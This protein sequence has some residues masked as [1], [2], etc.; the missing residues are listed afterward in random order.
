M[1]LAEIVDQTKFLRQVQEFIMPSSSCTIPIVENNQG[2][3]RGGV[4][5]SVGHGRDWPP[6]KAVFSRWQLI[7]RM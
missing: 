4:S 5:C 3:R 6:C 2:V 7:R 1:S